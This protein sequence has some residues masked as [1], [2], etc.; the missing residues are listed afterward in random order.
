MA[1]RTITGL[2]YYTILCL[3]F[4]CQETIQPLVVV[5]VVV[6]GIRLPLSFKLLF[7]FQCTV[8]IVCNVTQKMRTVSMVPWLLHHAQKELTC[9]LYLLEYRMIQ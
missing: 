6:T 8:C 7:T 9:A 2:V 3:Y 5:L 1:Y 4:N